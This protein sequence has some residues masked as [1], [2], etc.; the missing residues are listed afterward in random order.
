MMK[1]DQSPKPRGVSSRFLSPTDSGIPS[2]SP[3]ISPI[4]RN[5]DSR[6]HR[7]VEEIGFSRGLWP[8]SQS[9]TTKLDT[10]AD[11]LGNDRL[12]DFIE[13]RNDEKSEKGSA[14]EFLGRQR[15]CSDQF[16]RFEKEKEKEKE[17]SKENHRPIIGGSMRYTGKLRFPTKS[18]SST[19]NTSTH[20]SLV[21]GRLSVDENALNRRSSRPK[22]DSFNDSLDS[23][24][25]CSEICSS[26]DFSSPAVG[27]T[28]SST[29]YLSST[30]SSRRS[31]IEVSSKYMRVLP[32]RNR[33]GTSDSNIPNPASSENFPNSNK[34]TLKNAIKR[35]NSLT[36]YGTATSQWALSPGRSG[37]PPVSVENKGKLMSFS[38]LK[39]PSS[40]SRAKGVSNILSLGLEL[41]KSKKSSSSLWGPGVTDTAHQL[42]LL[43]NR[44][45]QWGYVNVKA[46]AVIQNKAKQAEGNLLN[47]LASLSKL[48]SSVVQKRIQLEKENLEMKLNTILNSQVKPL[49]AW[50]DIERQHSLAISMTKDCLH[51]VVCR[52]PL[53]EGAKAQKTVPLL[54]E[55]AEVVSKEKSLLQECSELFGVVSAL[56][57]VS[58][59]LILHASAYS[60][61]DRVVDATEKIEALRGAPGSFNSSIFTSSPPM[62]ISFVG[63]RG[64]HLEVL[65]VLKPWM[66]KGFVTLQD[67]SEREQ[68]DEYYHNQFLVV[69]D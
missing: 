12:N 63:L 21:P 40:P 69:N 38:T 11:H 10:L 68:F 23:E 14:H 46:D 44:L 66:E 32:A 67:V 55:L 48:Q 3:A 28:S 54:S 52:V 13:R 5:A 65:V 42:R 39:P 2:P 17:S 19:S 26:T 34:F 31:G 47:T 6:K 41:F 1:N 29:S 37:S 53:T 51:S 7:N 27:K 16:N 24:S 49:E 58:V 4:R 36:A 18:S 9:S 45:I 56:E 20:I 43:H 15:S 61:R 25:D 8:S 57:H 50:G 30:V 62:I 33:R 60:G 64:V 22:S 59:R 35:A